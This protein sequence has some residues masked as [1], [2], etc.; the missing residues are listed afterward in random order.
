M[1][2][3]EGS[4]RVPITDCIRA[5]LRVPIRVLAGAVSYTEASKE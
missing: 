3:L 5:P 2:F 1:G 4:R